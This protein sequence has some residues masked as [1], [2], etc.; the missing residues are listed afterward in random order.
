MIEERRIM[1]SHK[2]MNNKYMKVRKSINGK[3]LTKNT[4]TAKLYDAIYYFD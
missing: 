4:H 1:S 2:N 3:K